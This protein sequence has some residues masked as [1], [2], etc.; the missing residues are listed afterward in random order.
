MIDVKQA[1][2]TAIQSIKN[3]YEEKELKDLALEEVEYASENKM[4]LITLGFLVPDKNPKKSISLLLN[5][6]TKEYIR[7]YK[8]LKIDEETG[9]FQSMKIRKV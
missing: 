9:K 3:F 7:K 8:I 2:K 1:V 4:W 6:D 5:E